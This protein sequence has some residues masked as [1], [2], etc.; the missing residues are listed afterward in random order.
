MEESNMF[1]PEVVLTPEIVLGEIW[2]YRKEWERDADWWWGICRPYKDIPVGYDVNVFNDAEGE[3][4]R[5]VVYQLAKKNKEGHASP[6]NNVVFVFSIPTKE[7][8]EKE[9]IMDRNTF[10]IE[11]K[12]PAELKLK[13]LREIL[14]LDIQNIIGADI[15]TATIPQDDGAFTTVVSKA[16]PNNIY[17]VYVYEG[18]ETCKSIR[19]EMM[20]IKIKGNGQIMSSIGIEVF[21]LVEA[22]NHA[23]M[24]PGIVMIDTSKTIDRTIKYN[25]ETLKIETSDSLLLLNTAAAAKTWIVRPHVSRTVKL[26][27]MHEASYFNGKLVAVD[28]KKDMLVSIGDKSITDDGTEYMVGVFRVDKED[29]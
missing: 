26:M 5:A 12:S 23:L 6:T 24:Y 18:R 16:T 29:L 20:S 13:A 21:S 22:M 4:F 17:S 10:K 2:Q 8:Y 3:P 28:G 11:K 19:K 15:S 7:E 25:Q 14:D 27:T 1:G 9:T